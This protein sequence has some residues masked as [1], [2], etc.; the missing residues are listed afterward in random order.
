[1]N[2][3]DDEKRIEYLC[4]SCLLF[5]KYMT[6]LCV[7]ILYTNMFIKSQSCLV[8]IVMVG[9]K[10]VGHSGDSRGVC[11]YELVFCYKAAWICR[12]KGGS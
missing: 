4:S 11:P 7:C 2:C 8:V 6:N 10:K 5:K 9:R 1:M 3:D 12:G